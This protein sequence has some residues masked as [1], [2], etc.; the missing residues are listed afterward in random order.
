MRIRTAIRQRGARTIRWER[1]HAHSRVKV[2]WRSKG[3]C[4]ACEE[5]QGPFE[6]SH[7]V[8]RGNNISEPWCSTPELT[9]A[10]CIPC[11][12]SIDRN[13]APQRLAHLRTDALER[14]CQTYGLDYV[15]SLLDPLDAIR[16]VVRTLDAAGFR[17]D[18]TRLSIERAA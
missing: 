12:N 16:A 15:D 8:G 4:E 1:W 7:L 10:L 2:M 9:A 18:A 3:R 5:S 14:L 11:H 13:V 17:W 6:W